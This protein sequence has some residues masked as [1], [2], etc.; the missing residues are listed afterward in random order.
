MWDPHA[1]GMVMLP[2]I[3]ISDG[4][5]IDNDGVKLF[6]FIFLVPRERSA[7]LLSLGFIPFISYT[8]ELFHLQLHR[9]ARLE[10]G[11]E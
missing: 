11:A 8:Y 7:A 4:S 2:Q 6:W 9:Q 1:P 5:R 3:P 10:S